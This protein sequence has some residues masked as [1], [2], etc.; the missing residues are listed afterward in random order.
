MWIPVGKGFQAEGTTGAKA[1]GQGQNLRKIKSSSVAAAESKRGQVLTYGVRGLAR[2]IP[3]ST[4]Q[5]RE[6]ILVFS[7]KVGS[8]L[9]HFKLPVSV[10]TQQPEWL[11]FN[12]SHIVSPICSKSPL[13]LHI[14]VK[15]TVLT[16]ASRSALPMRSGP[17]CLSDLNILPLCLGHG[18]PW[19]FLKLK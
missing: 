14:R 7:E 17:R 8:V 18:A 9:S 19:L 11:C 3:C 10:C 13:H 5:A 4:L 12:P 6:R 15:S 16:V 1:L 2:G